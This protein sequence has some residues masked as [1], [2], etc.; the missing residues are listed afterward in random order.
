MKRISITFYDELVD[1]LESNAKEKN[2]SLAQYVRKL[3][4]VGLKVET[5]S[6]QQN[7][8]QNSIEDQFE[9]LKLDLQKWLQKILVADYE[10]L[11][12]L[13]YM[14]PQMLGKEKEKHLE[15]MKKAKLHAEGFVHGALG[16]DPIQS[17]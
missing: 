2:I 1:L 11:Y 10:S 4:E 16:V 5:Y 13:R 17:E 15:F 7:E 12:L 8:T 14:I 9:N 6:N 3:V